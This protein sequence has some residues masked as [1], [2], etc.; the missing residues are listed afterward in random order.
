MAPHTSLHMEARSTCSSGEKVP[1][2]LAGDHPHGPQNPVVLGG[3][4]GLFLLGQAGQK[5]R[6]LCRQGVVHGLAIPGLVEPLQV[7]ID[8][9][10][11]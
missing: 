3:P 1:V 5:C 11:L 10:N 4:V 9:R 6:R 8:R 7:G 2:R